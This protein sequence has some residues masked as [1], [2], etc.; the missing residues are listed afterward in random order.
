VGAYVETEA[1]FLLN[2]EEKLDD[3]DPERIKDLP[4]IPSMITKLREKHDAITFLTSSEIVKEF[5]TWT[6]DTKKIPSDNFLSIH[7]VRTEAHRHSGKARFDDEF[8][9]EDVPCGSSPLGGIRDPDRVSEAETHHGRTSETE[10]RIPLLPL[11]RRV[12]VLGGRSLAYPAIRVR[13]P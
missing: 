10:K 11:S 6:M 7:T 8:H 12:G 5:T 4:D 3:V 13:L 2:L 9:V 1:G